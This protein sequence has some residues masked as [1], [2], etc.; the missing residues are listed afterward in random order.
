MEHTLKESIAITWASVTMR[1]K[2]LAR[3]HS[4]L[5][6]LTGVLVFIV[7]FTAFRSDVFFSLKNFR[8]ILVQISV[9]TVVAAGTTLLMVSGG[10]DLSVGAMMSL[11]GVVAGLMM[12]NDIPLGVTLLVTLLFA[13]ILGGLNGILAAW[14]PSHPFVVTLGV[15][16]LFQGIAIGIT[17]GKPLSGLYDEF[18]VLSRTN[19]VFNLPYPVWIAATLLIACGLLL[20][21]TV[22]GRH[23]YAIG[24]NELAAQ[25]AGV[26]VE[27][28]KVIVYAI[29]GVLVGVAAL[30]L[31]A[32]IASAQP[33]MGAGYELQAIAAVAVG[34]TP[35][36]GGR[37]GVVGTLLGVLLLGVISNSLNLLGISGAYQ[38]VL[39]GAV[40]VFAVMAQR[41]R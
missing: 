34:G 38:F 29:N 3:S 20:S 27:W 41:S 5:L 13:M 40:I 32:R 23:L 35:L 12:I 24:G 9:L 31:S 39:Q 2:E 30:M 8:N 28:T 19:L 18:V 10:I 22:F 7:I 16:I 36:A 4:A 1:L 15:S 11:V 14:S 33:W 25:L 37:G 26:R 6:A 21:F 17:A